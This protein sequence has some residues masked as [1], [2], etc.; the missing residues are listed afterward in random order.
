MPSR[1][2]APCAR[3]PLEPRSGL[4]GGLT[5]TLTGALSWEQHGHDWPNRASSRFVRAAGLRWHVQEMGRGSGE[6]PKILLLHGTGASTHSWRRVLP[7]LAP[8]FSLLA[9]D[10]PGH[11]FTEMPLAQ[12]MSL[13]GMSHLIGGLLERL[14]FE[15]DLVVGHSAGAAILARMI[16]DGT[17]RPRALVS[18]NGALMPLPGASSRLFPAAARLLASTGVVPWVFSLHAANRDLV[19][20]LLG[21]TGSR[22]EADDLRSYRRL[23]LNPGHV[24]A[25]L[26]MMAHW[27]LRALAADLAQLRL[28]LTLIVGG[29]DRMIP[30]ADAERLRTIL[31]QARIVRLDGLG[32][33]AHEEQPRTV[34]E[35]VTAA[36]D[37]T[38]APAAT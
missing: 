26:Q 18:L 12:R 30:P 28:P 11:G 7:L 2:P 21:N 23:L 27:D 1:C 5:G 33:L 17:I 31:P 35:L 25:A 9:L 3:R 32:H 20:R 34:A 24:S 19:T 13:P 37:E 14:A 29:N 15:P 16:L 6:A 22:M 36:Y 4:I 8:H 10:L 38:R